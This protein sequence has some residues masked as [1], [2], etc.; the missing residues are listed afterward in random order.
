MLTFTIPSGA[1]EIAT[2]TIPG[3]KGITVQANFSAHRTSG[4]LGITAVLL[5]PLATVE[6]A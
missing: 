2:P 5:S 4:E 1:F 6:G 3:P